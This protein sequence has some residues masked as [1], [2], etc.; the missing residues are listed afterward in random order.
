MHEGF[1][2]KGYPT[3]YFKSASGKLLQYSGK[4]SKDKITSFIKKN[5]EKTS[6]QSSIKEEL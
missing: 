6:Q 5:K 3:L 4:R 1:D 2:V